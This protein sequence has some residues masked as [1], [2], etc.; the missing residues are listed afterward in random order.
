MSTRTAELPVIA[1]LDAVV[2]IDGKVCGWATSMNWSEDFEVQGIRTLGFH[3]D[4]GWKSMGY[5]CSIR[6]GT[7]VLFAGDTT[8]DAV[9]LETRRSILKS[10]LAQFEV[11]GPDAVTGERK[12][13]FTLKDCKCGTQD[14]NFDTGALAA[15]N[16]TWRCREVAPNATNVSMVMA[17]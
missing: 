6:V 4:R 1:G 11:Y 13:L 14:I 10:G 15:R 16:T 12:H 3:G 2:V 7:L 8:Q 5:N 9:P 17:G